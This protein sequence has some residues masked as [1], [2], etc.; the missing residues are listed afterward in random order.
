MTRW[1]KRKLF[2]GWVAPGPVTYGELMSG[3]YSW[4]L[5][6]NSWR[7]WVSARHAGVVDQGFEVEL[8]PNGLKRD[9]YG[10]PWVKSTYVSER[11]R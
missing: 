9:G 6:F 10:R 1:I 4:F 5:V 7:L 8:G 2:A 3:D 11:W